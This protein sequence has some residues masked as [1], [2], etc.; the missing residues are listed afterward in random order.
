MKQNLFLSVI[1]LAVL[2]GCSCKKA[3]EAKAADGLITFYDTTW[4][5]EYISGPRIAFDGLYPETKPNIIFTAADTKF[6]GNNSC[7]VYSGKY[8]KKE[9]YIHFGDA[10]K[11]MRFCEGGGEET[12]MNMLGKVNKWAIDSDR[13]LV[14]LTDDIPMM[15][16]KKVTKTQQ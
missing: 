15:R 6:G 12:F 16:F 3:S 1:L 11:T 14:L 10:I 7:N 2:S 5:L 9:N 13:K 8:T 4:E